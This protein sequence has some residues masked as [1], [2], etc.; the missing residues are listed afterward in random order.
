MASSTTKPVAIVS[1]ISEKM[2]RLKPSRYITPKVPMIDTGTAMLGMIAARRS[3]R[4]TVTMAMTSNTAI[5]S[6][7]SVSNSEARIVMLRSEARVMSIS[8]GM[9]AASCVS[10]L[11][12]PSTVSMI[13]A[14]GWR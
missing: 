4:K 7:F 9:A 12:T 2:S 8:A 3:A 13:L 5:T 14:P 11:F 6:V 1:A 10:A